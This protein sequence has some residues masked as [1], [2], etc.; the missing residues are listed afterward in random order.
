MKG[1]RVVVWVDEH[2]RE[3]EA[4][5][6]AD[7]FEAIREM[8]MDIPGAVGELIPEDDRQWGGYRSH[9]SAMWKLRQRTRIKQERRHT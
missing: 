3:V 2:H 9:N 1:K 6:S 8:L 4:Y 5:G 7:V